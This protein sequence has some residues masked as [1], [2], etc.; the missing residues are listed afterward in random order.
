MCPGWIRPQCTIVRKGSEELSPPL[1]H[2]TV[3]WRFFL[4]SQRPGQGPYFVQGGLGH[5]SQPPPWRTS[6]I[7]RSMGRN[8][9]KKR[10]YQRCACLHVMT[11]MP[12]KM[13][14]CSSQGR[15]KSSKESICQ[16]YSAIGI[17]VNSWSF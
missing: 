17:D 6:A 8:H 9:P 11:P 10:C 2:Y 5:Q 13:L 12:L 15:L 4:L 3:L 7:Y 1:S 16:L 14:T